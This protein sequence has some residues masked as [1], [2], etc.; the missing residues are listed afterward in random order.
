[1]QAGL[2]TIACANEWQGV[3]RGRLRSRKPFLMG[4][5]VNES[6]FGE[7]LT[8]PGVFP[9]RS[10]GAAFAARREHGASM[11][12]TSRKQSSVGRNSAFEKSIGKKL[13]RILSGTK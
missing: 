13:R 6:P 12:E 10:A 4:R 3:T 2:G 7:A 8:V 11:T 9:D 5:P 1:M